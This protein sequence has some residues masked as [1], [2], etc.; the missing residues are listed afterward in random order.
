MSRRKRRQARQATEDHHIEWLKHRT[1]FPSPEEREKIILL[2]QEL[3]SEFI[4][5]MLMGVKPNDARIQALIRKYGAEE[6][7]RAT[8]VLGEMDRGALVAD[9]A[10]SYREYRLR[11]ARFGDGLKFYTAREVDDLYMNH[12]DQLKNLLLEGKDKPLPAT[13]EDINRLLL[14]GWNDWKDIT[15]PA[16]PPRP[17]DFHAPQPASYPA[18]I[19]ELLEWG[20]ELKMSHDFVDETDFANWRK[21]IPALARMALDPGLLNGWPA[22]KASWAPWHAIHTLG[23]LQAWESAPAL[24]KLAD[25]E[26]DWLSDHLPHIWG[27]MGMEVEPSL[28]M[29]LEDPSASAKRRGLAAESLSSMAEDNEAMETKVVRGFEKILKNT[30][31]FDRTLNAYLI[32]FLREMESVEDVWD[33]IESAFDEERVNVDVISPE[34]LE[35]DDFDDEFDDE[36]DEDEED[37]EEEID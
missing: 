2:R 28:W 25:L 30:K 14:I 29:I 24:A 20:D 6:V 15:P 7:E 27:D 33:V 4:K 36:F 16:P 13:E 21:H 31:T 5:L 18:P 19:N 12:M 9:D 10:S 35:E 22:E 3:S 37:D 32:H 26:N 17:A 11:Y 34:D 23:A 8:R 1:G